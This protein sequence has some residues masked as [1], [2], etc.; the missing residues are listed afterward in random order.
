MDTNFPVPAAQYLRMSTEHQQYS[1][2]N[3]RAVIQRY[4]DHGGFVIVQTY[5]DAAKSGVQL[6]R[7]AGLR[8][9]LQ[10]VVTGTVSY[11]HIL[12]FDVSRWGRFQDCDEAAHYEFLC[13]SAGVPVHYCAEPFANDGSVPSSILKA[14]KRTMAAEYSRELGTKVLAGQ[15]RL[16]RLGFKQGGVPGY[17]LRRML[18]D[19]QGHPK[20][21]LESGERKSI[22]TDRVILVPG[23]R[24]EVEIVRSIY[25][26]FVSER[27]TVYWISSELNRRGVPYT[28]GGS[29]DYFAVYNILVHPKYIGCHVFGRSSQRLYTPSVPQPEANWTV[30]PGAFDPIVDQ[31]T[32]SL[33]RRLLEA[34]VINRSN[35]RLLEELKQLL[36]SEGRLTLELIH[37]CPNVASPSTYRKRFGSLREAYRRIGYNSPE[38]FVPTDVRRRTRALRDKLVAEVQGLFPFDVRVVRR[39]NRSRPLLLVRR[40]FKV[41]V[42]VARSVKTWK[43]AL[44]WCVDPVSRERRLTTLLCRLK[45][46][47]DTVLDLHLLDRI[48][49]KK[50]FFL[51]LDDPILRSAERILNLSEFV[52][53]TERIRARPQ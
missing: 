50:R 41:A 26:M 13:K 8:Q 31:Q 3:Q 16:A 10:D 4:A 36:A 20:H 35:E 17:G 7:R 38:H 42:L 37:T 25:R 12:V 24:E 18:T 39:C 1:L 23:P 34:R 46:D 6:R 27:R 52:N 40:R 48:D 45:K 19:S 49:R 11:K 53:A 33:A 51:Q 29:W 43:T 21:L 32:F 28:G 9:L 44:R 15:H 2:E 14:L 47:N 30:T 22:A 5:S